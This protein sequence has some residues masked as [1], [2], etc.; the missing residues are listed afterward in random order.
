MK[1]ATTTDLAD[2][3]LDRDASQLG[4]WIFLATEV[5]FF[6]SLFAVFAVYRWEH[7]AAFAAAA[8]KMEQGL[9]AL[10]TA[11]LLTSSLTMAAAAHRSGEERHR[12]AARWLLAT[13]VL[14]AAFLGIKGLEYAHHLRDGLWPG[15]GFRWDGDA[16]QAGPARLYFALYFCLTG[17]HALHMLAGLAA[18]AVAARLSWTGAINRVS[19]AAVENT[20]LYWHFVDV[21]WIWLFP[22]LYLLR[23]S[24]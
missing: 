17:L 16:A 4:M 23:R 8:A 6:G 14:G 24:G 5:L 10:N 19:R 21:V 11:V 12:D 13:I 22:V 3:P 15:P 18:A 9:G 1:T 2:S 7:A 20:G